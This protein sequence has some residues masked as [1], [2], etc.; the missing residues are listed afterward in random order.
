ME[1]VVCVEFVERSTNASNMAVLE[2][3]LISGY[4]SDKSSFKRIRDVEGV[5][6]SLQLFE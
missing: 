5:G 2:V 3:S 6:V 1:A 4:S